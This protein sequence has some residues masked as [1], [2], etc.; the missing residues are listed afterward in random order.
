MLRKLIAAAALAA[1]VGAGAFW[2]LTVP[3][4][5][6]ASSLAPRAPDLANGRTMFYAGG[7]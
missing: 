3:Q 5:I 4:T 1:L 6:A 7:C 2:L